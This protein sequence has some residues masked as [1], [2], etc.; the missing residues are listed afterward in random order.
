MLVV[1]TITFSA[2]I[3]LADLTVIDFD[4]ETSQT[5]GPNDLYPDGV[6]IRGQIHI[7]E[8]VT[9]TIEGTSEQSPYLVYFGDDCELPPIEQGSLQ[10]NGSIDC[11]YVRFGG[12]ETSPTG[13]PAVTEWVISNI[14]LEGESCNYANCVFTDC[15]NWTCWFG[16]GGHE[17]SDASVTGCDF[18]VGYGDCAGTQ[19]M[20]IGPGYGETTIQDCNFTV[21][22]D[23]LVLLIMIEDAPGDLSI[24]GCEIVGPGG[25]SSRT[26]AFFIDGGS[27]CTGEGIVWNEITDCAA[28]FDIFRNGPNISNNWIEGCVVGAS[29]S[30]LVDEDFFYNNVIDGDG[31]Y[32]S[33]G[34]WARDGDFPDD[35]IPAYNCIIVNCDMG[36]RGGADAAWLQYCCVDNSNT[37][38]LID[39]E[40]G[41]GYTTDTPNFAPD[42]RHLTYA[43]ISLINCGTGTDSD[44]AAADISLYGGPYADLG[45]GGFYAHLPASIPSNFTFVDEPYKAQGDLTFSSGTEITASAGARFS[46]G[47]S[48]SFQ[49]DDFDANGSSANN[50]EFVVNSG[51]TFLGSGNGAVFL[52]TYFDAECGDAEDD[53]IEIGSND[54]V[55]FDNSEIH[56]GDDIDIGVGATLTLDNYT[57]LDINDSLVAVGTGSD[58]IVIQME[59]DARMD[60][61]TLDLTDL[62]LVMTRECTLYVVCLYED[63][64]TFDVTLGSA[65][66]MPYYTCPVD[67]PVIDIVGSRIQID[68]EC[69]INS[70]TY[71]DD[72]TVII[73]T[74]EITGACTVEFTGGT[75][76]EI[77][78]LYT[79]AN[80]VKFDSCTGSIGWLIADSSAHVSMTSDCAVDIE[81]GF[82]VLADATVECDGAEFTSVD[83]GVVVYGDAKFTNCTFDGTELIQSEGAL[84]CSLSTFKNGAYFHLDYDGGG[85]ESP[86][87]TI[88]DCDFD[89]AYLR[90]DHASKLYQ[91]IYNCTFQNQ[92]SDSA[93]AAMFYSGSVDVEKCG[94]YNIDEEGI[95]LDD[96]DADIHTCKLED[97]GNGATDDAAIRLIGSDPL[98]WCTGIDSIDGKGILAGGGSNLELRGPADKQQEYTPGK[99]EIAGMASPANSV[100]LMY[101]DNSNVICKGGINWFAI[102]TSSAGYFGCTLGHDTFDVADNF[103]WDLDDND[104]GDDCGDYF[105]P[106]AMWEN[107][108]ETPQGSYQSCVSGYSGRLDEEED[109]VDVEGEVEQLYHDG[110]YFVR[111]SEY[112]NA[113]GSFREIL[114][115]HPEHP[116]AI[117]AL[118]RLFWAAREHDLLVSRGDEE[119]PLEMPTLHGE[120]I[121]RRDSDGTP[122][123][124]AEFARTCVPRAKVVMA[125]YTEALTDY[126]TIIS[127]PI[128]DA[129]EIYARLDSQRVAVYAGGGSPIASVGEES[130]IDR[131]RQAVEHSRALRRLVSRQRDLLAGLELDKE[132]PIS[133]KI[134][135]EEEPLVPHEFELQQAYPNPFNASAVI[136]FSLREDVEVRM[137]V[138][139]ILGRKVATLVDKPMVA[140]WHSV[141]FD[142]SHLPSG[143]YIYRIKAGS[144]VDS[145]KMVLI[146]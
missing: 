105:S 90:M 40:G 19:V 64:V 140:G 4:I 29:F 80:L 120:L 15:D 124:L 127:D 91:S 35:I 130:R 142:G 77:D 32:W 131:A 144:F 95:F 63:N 48:I 88:T 18:I 96:C 138:F 68:Y 60:V 139:N 69:G 33:L 11:E 66:I 87:T 55:R 42:N 39:C 110:E 61:H 129:E 65:I 123:E 30:F 75:Y 62:K 119:G 1:A 34:I 73:G 36:V 59:D 143:V 27:G 113:F 93:G 145:K 97:C 12:H 25:E 137:D 20:V 51:V 114:Q 146:R 13:N 23:A 85:Q 50:V 118:A 115:D 49:G 117:P 52:H 16:I 72:D 122:Q 10:V 3:G 46:V 126:Q 141:S 134:P 128:S 38:K 14:C 17:G 83:N 136:K 54:D 28:G 101:L 6:L 31:P 78:S 132:P 133:S 116:L 112:T 22:D 70:T 121:S 89:G 56:V 92:N 81:T 8:G 43:N 99:N 102:D 104:L 57:Y 7:E 76:L 5:W 107:C 47:G 100:Y 125:N 135:E 94:F 108:D 2:S 37:V 26:T 103:W 84:T 21:E 53:D 111:R 9:L 106:A 86:T 58:D 109:W 67:L 79:T 24:K 82:Y 41:T 98:I 44:G 71:F 74:F 45:P